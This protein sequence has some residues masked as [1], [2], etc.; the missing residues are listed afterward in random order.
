MHLVIVHISFNSIIIVNFFAVIS[1]SS[2]QYTAAEG[3]NESITI[4]LIRDGDTSSDVSI[5][6][7]ISAANLGKSV[8][9]AIL[10]TIKIWG[11]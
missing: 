1:F 11:V 8:K 9:K 5:N 7:S 10:P 3:V 2:T 6:V 4:T